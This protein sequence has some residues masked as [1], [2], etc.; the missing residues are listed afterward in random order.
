RPRR[1]HSRRHRPL[2][3]AGPPPPLR[4]HNPSQPLSIHAIPALSLPTTDDS[5][6]TALGLPPVFPSKRNTLRQKKL[7]GSSCPFPVNAGPAR[8]STARDSRSRACRRGRTRCRC[9]ESLY[10]RTPVRWHVQNRA[11]KPPQSP[12]HGPSASSLQFPWN[13][14]VYDSG[15]RRRPPHVGVL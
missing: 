14:N 4:R 6:E 5:L 7:A 8:N 15:P 1:C 12:P 9:L 11:G 2:R 10:A 3:A 13:L